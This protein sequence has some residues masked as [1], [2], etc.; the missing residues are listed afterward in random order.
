MYHFEF[1]FMLESF[2]LLEFWNPV[3][4]WNLE[5]E[6]SYGGKNE[7]LSQIYSGSAANK[8]FHLISLSL[9][10]HFCEMTRMIA[11]SPIVTKFL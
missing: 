6:A 7:R 2:S 9:N 4:W 10:F 5:K 8:Y 1:I 3:L 11:S